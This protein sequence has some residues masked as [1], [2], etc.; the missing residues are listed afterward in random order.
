MTDKKIKS[1]QLDEIAKK[2]VEVINNS[3][4]QIFD[5][6]ENSKKECRRLEEELMLI[7]TQLKVVVEEITQMENTLDICKKILGEVKRNFIKY[8]ER[9]IKEAYENIDKVHIDI[10]VKREKEKNLI[11]RREE[12]ELRLKQEKIIHKKAEKLISQV[13][14]TLNY[15]AGDLQQA[16]I[17]IEDMQEKQMLGIKIIEAH[18]NERYR[19]AREIHDGPV[20]SMANVVLKA[21][22]CEK[23][24]DSNLVKAKEVLKQLK[25][26]VKESLNDFRGIIYNLRPMSLDDIGLIPTIEKYVET[27][28]D[29]TE[30]NTQLNIKG[31]V[32]KTKPVIALT[33]YRIIQEATTNIKKYANADKVIINIE[34]VEKKKAIINI[35]D[36]GD[37]FDVEN[38]KIK[39]TG[40]SGGFG[41]FSMKERAE[42][43]NGSFEIKSKIGKGTKI[44]VIIPLE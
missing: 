33:I 21:E 23:L 36:D 24:M 30:I 17:Q 22:I 37:G 39:S 29:D 43:V 6:V 16:S 40:E 18:E 11:E 2:T 1:T 7:K 8:T 38:I 12:F 9:D 3:Q 28:K 13:A 26:L 15:L 10:A 34:F 14:V 27:Y 25:G 32:V 5:I 42:I 20:Q 35:S 19:M 44:N 31:A 41:L 4:I